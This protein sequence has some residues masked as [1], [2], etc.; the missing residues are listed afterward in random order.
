MPA[1]LTP[2]APERAERA[3]LADIVSG[4]RIVEIAR[5]RPT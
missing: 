2:A 1:H 5:E 4:K 3:I